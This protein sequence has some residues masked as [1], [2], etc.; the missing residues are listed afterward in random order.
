MNGYTTLG[1]GPIPVLFLHGWFGDHSQWDAL[2]PAIDGSQ[3]TCVFMDYRGY[4]L[5]RHL[6]G[7]Y[8]LAEIG[9]D[10]LALADHLGWEKFHVVGHSMG[11]MAVQWLATFGGGR[12]LSGVA[13]TPVSAGSTPFDEAG[14]ALFSGA[15]DDVN[16]RAGII[17]FTTGS[18]HNPVWS[19]GLARYSE[20]HATR[21]AFAAYLLAWAKTNFAADAQGNPTPLLVLPGEFDAGVPADFVR[22]TIMTYFPNAQLHVLANAGH[23]PMNE[24]P[25]DLAT[26][27]QAFILQHHS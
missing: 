17:H 7:D 13:I 19:M 21:E 27:L 26:R 15:A 3:F 22:A 6:T 16:K 8:T 24:T 2:L 20:E 18:R 5:S 12:V 14:W 11:G 23:Y 1:T 10:A 25:I 9:R 4:S